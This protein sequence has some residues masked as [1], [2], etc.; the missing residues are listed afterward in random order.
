MVDLD[1]AVVPAAVEV[2]MPSKRDRRDHCK[3]LMRALRSRRRDENPP[4]PRGNPSGKASGLAAGRNPTL[5]EI[6]IVERE[7][8]RVKAEKMGQSWP[9]GER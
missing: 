5:S 9:H 7:I 8:A 2:V 6:S 1:Q 4:N 3:M